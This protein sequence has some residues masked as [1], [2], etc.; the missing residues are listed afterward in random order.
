MPS[1]PN[2]NFLILLWKDGVASARDR[3][4]ARL[5]PELSQIAAARLRSERG[6][7]LS[8]GDL[9]ND[10]V[11]RLMQADRLE[12]A[13]RQHFVAL[14]SRLMR[15]I[16]IEHARQKAAAKRDHIKVELCTRVDGGQR[17]DLISLETA[18]VRLGAIEPSLMEL[19]EMRYFGGMTVADV[20][21][22]TGWS[23]RTVKRRWDVAK[24]WLLD[25]LAA[26]AANG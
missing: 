24:A 19:V 3:L 9:I 23:E 20:A 26:D 22:V 11:V 17:V 15:H 12:L 14:A 21:T 7:S 16:L 6:T 5:H 4:I 10:A 2:T 1:E 13:D 8:T 25:A 18:L